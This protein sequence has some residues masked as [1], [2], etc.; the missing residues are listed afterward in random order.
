MIRWMDGSARFTRD[1]SFV[2]IDNLLFLS[3]KG[4]ETFSFTLMSLASRLLLFR[5]SNV[6]LWVKVPQKSSRKIENW[7]VSIEKIWGKDWRIGGLLRYSIIFRILLLLFSS[8]L[9]SFP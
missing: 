4:R 7:T 8:R 9:N 1:G 5:I 6:E 2:W 3:K